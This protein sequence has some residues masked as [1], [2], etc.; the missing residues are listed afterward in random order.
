MLRALAIR[1]MAIIRTLEVEFCPGLSVLTGETGAGKSIVIG[2]LGAVLGGRVGAD[3]V[4]S[5]A[6]RA[7]V[8]AVFDIAGS[9]EAQAGVAQMGFDAA[10]GELALTREITDTGKSSARISG[11][12]ATVGQLR[13][14][15]EWLVDLHGQHEHQALLNPRRHMAFLD[16]WAGPDHLDLAAR[17]SRAWRR[18]KD[19]EG[20]LRGIQTDARERLR[21]AD[22]YRFQANEIRSASLVTGEDERLG[23]E[24]RRLRNVERLR[25]GIVGVLA[26]LGDGGR[27]AVSDVVASAAREIETVATLDATLEPVSSALISVRYDLEE[28]VRALAAYLD[29][30]EADPNRLDSVQERLATIS[31][32][33]RKYGATVEEVNAF[34]DD[35]EQRLDAL[36]QGEARTDQLNEA[37]ARARAE[38]DALMRELGAARRDAAHR[39][40]GA[41]TSELNQLAMDRALFRV[42]IGDAPP[43]ENGSD[44][45]EFMLAPNPGEPLRPLAKIASGGEISRVMLAIKSATASRSPLPTM[46]FDEVDVGIGG[47][48]AGVV[49]EKMRGLATSAQVI[50]ITHLPQIAVYADT[51]YAIRKV[52]EEGRS[53]VQIA[54]LDAEGRVEELARML[55]GADVTDAARDHV[56]EMLVR[57]S[58]A[59][60]ARVSPAIGARSAGVPPETDVRSAGVSAATDVRGP[61]V[62]RETEARSAGVPPATG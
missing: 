32:L 1:D 15:G 26:S 21:L 49:G 57:L 43:A 3:L 20:E 41:V 14:I 30:L 6:S 2:A 52:D 31:D 45:V 54:A 22:L 17:T 11:R 47:R 29:H 36:E 59:R 55:A 16:E 23:D 33:K 56:R 27:D 10:D 46:V 8:D 25:D 39:F 60:T 37:I 58:E 50:C 44:A 38:S 9:Q 4:R 28:A 5:G 35:A 51:Q 42:D 13:Q 7:I 48:T 12:P 34:A 53:V 19:L 40:E 61:G 62:P 24:L 18:L